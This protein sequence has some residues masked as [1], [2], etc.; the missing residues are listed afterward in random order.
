LV[1]K[2]PGAT[3]PVVQ[4]AAGRMHSLAVT[5]TGWLYT[6][7]YNFYGQLGRISHLGTANP[8]PIAAPVAIAGGSAVG[9]VATGPDSYQTLAVLAG[10]A[11]ISK[12]SVSPRKLSAA[13]K[14]TLRVRFRLN[15]AAAV[16]ITLRRV[17]SW[18]L[19]GGR[20]VAAIRGNSTHRPCTGLTPVGGASPGSLRP[21]R[22]ASP[23]R[24]GPQATGSGRAPTA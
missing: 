6:F 17:T 2:L 24:A 1:V 19:V 14:L 13:R 20:C 8:N 18:R 3:G 9:S 10:V 15:E 4:I 12:P 23:S 16:T 7:G 11:T 5:S 22:T 21:A